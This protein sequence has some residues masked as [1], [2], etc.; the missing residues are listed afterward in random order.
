MDKERRSSPVLI[1]ALQYPIKEKSGSMSGR[2]GAAG[3]KSSCRKG[4]N[5]DPAGGA[6]LI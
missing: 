6:T 1:G 3:E 5:E 2:R 4:D